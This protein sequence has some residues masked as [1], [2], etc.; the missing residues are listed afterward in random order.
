LQGIEKLAHPLL[1]S[2]ADR[3]PAPKNAYPKEKHQMKKILSALVAVAF[4][5]PVLAQ[6]PAAAPAAPAKP[7][8]AAPAAPVAPA[9]PAAAPAAAAKP[10]DKAAKPPKKKKAKK[11]QPGDG[12]STQPNMTK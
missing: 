1:L 5:I 7:V 8:A 9:A 4:A 11:V 10:A 2:D 6:T 12:T 3:S